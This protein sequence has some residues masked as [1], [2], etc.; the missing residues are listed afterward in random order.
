MIWEHNSI[1]NM[2][3]KRVIQDTRQD[4]LRM[5]SLRMPEMEFV[6]CTVNDKLP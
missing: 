2:Q 5:K 3:R 4:R 6:L 1:A